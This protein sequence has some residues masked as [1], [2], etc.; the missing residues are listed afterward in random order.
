MVEITQ[1]IL[2]SSKT[3]RLHGVVIRDGGLLVF[4]PV[5]NLVKLTT[6]YVDIQNNGAMEIGSEDCKFEGNAEV[7]LTGKM[8]PVVSL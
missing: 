5:P 8:N 2:L 6:R 1:P 4:D 7:L 3:A